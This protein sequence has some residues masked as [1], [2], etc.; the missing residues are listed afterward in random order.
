MSNNNLIEDYGRL[1]KNSKKEQYQLKDGEYKLNLSN[2]WPKNQIKSSDRFC[3]YLITILRKG[4]RSLHTTSKSEADQFVRLINFIKD[5]LNSI[6]NPKEF[7]T[8]L[9]DLNNTQILMDF[10]FK[11]STRLLNYFN[12]DILDLAL[13]MEE[14]HFEKSNEEIAYENVCSKLWLLKSDQVK[15]LESNLLEL[16]LPIE[17]ET[18]NILINEDLDFKLQNPDLGFLVELSSSG[19]HIVTKLNITEEEFSKLFN[20]CYKMELKKFEKTDKSDNKLKI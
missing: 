3:R 11:D 19:K 20:D 10:L 7:Y 1:I 13:D 12:K 2:I 15:I 16:E 14:I 9:N 8:F 4:L 17:F 6:D 18:V 5:S